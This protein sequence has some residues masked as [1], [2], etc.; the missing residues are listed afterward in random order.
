MRWA[1]CGGLQGEGDTTGRRAGDGKQGGWCWEVSGWCASL[2]LTRWEWPVTMSCSW[3]LL[4]PW[5]SCCW[6][7]FWHFFFEVRRAGPGGVKPFRA[8]ETPGGSESGWILLPAPV[9]SPLPHSLESHF[10]HCPHLSWRIAG[11]LI[12]PKM[13]EALSITS[14]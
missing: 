3:S 2:C 5:D 12:L 10:Y 4:P 8:L 6:H 9:C 11:K 7:C 14:W 1:K 13:P